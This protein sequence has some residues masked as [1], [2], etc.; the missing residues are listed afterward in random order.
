MLVGFS[1]WMCLYC[2]YAYRCV[3]VSNGT[4]TM[5]TSE[6]SRQEIK[7]RHKHTH[8]HDETMT[9]STTTTDLDVQAFDFMKCLPFLVWLFT[10]LVNSF[11]HTVR[12]TTREW[13]NEEKKGESIMLHAVR[14]LCIYVCL[15]MF[16]YKLHSISTAIWF[17]HALMKM[18]FLPLF[19]SVFTLAVHVCVLT[20]SNDA[21]PT[22]NDREINWYDEVVDKE[23]EQKKRMEKTAAAK[24][25]TVRNKWINEW[26]KFLLSSLQ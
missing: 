21:T 11:T 10:R 7:E 20:C 24:Q 8:A 16:C 13:T 6:N 2:A 18:I 22:A 1:V 15:M 19:M 4:W 14:L 9:T 12:D 3:G 23:S 26:K 5:S 25:D 17:L